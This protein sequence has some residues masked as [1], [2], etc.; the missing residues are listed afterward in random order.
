M[1]G[2]EIEAIT[3]SAKAMQEVAK[4]GDKALDVGR[5][6]GGWLNRMFGDGIENAVA[7]HWSDRVKARRVEAAIYDWER[8]TTL[9]H[10]AEARLNTKGIKS[11]RLVPPKIALALIENATVEYD[12][13]LHTLW[14][15]LLAT[16]LDANAD[17]IHKKYISILS[18]LTSIDAKLLDALY[19]ASNNKDKFGREALFYGDFKNNGQPFE[20]ISIITLNRLGLVSP[21][22]IVFDNYEPAV[23]GYRPE[24]KTV[25]TT[26]DLDGIEFT[27][28]GE[29]FCKAVI[30]E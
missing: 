25:R 10:K 27:T 20:E 5:G 14:A 11:T 24:R 2:N 1:T 18:D 8:L 19:T 23:S 12:D 21:E 16:G 26:G 7:L 28:L 3:E 30:L 22:S 17:G 4:L 9:L 6:V 15:N 13:D 29:A